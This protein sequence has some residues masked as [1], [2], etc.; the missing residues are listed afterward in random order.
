MSG[1]P[2]SFRCALPK[3]ST[4]LMR[5]CDTLAATSNMVNPLTALR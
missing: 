1:G 5:D 2:L 4:V 3:A